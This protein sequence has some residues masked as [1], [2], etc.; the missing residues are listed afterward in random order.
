MKFRIEK[1]FD[2]DVDKIKDKRLLKK[3]RTFISIIE[4]TETI[5]Q[6]PHIKKIEGYAS[7]YRIQVGEYRLGMEAVLN[8]EVVLI[9]FL[10]RKDIYRHFPK[11][12]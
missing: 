3:L 6:I 8:K 7:F 12:G 4:N 5:R 11:R 10:H 1:S 9:R 2:K